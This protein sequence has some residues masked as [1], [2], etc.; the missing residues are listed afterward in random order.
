[1]RPADEILASSEAGGPRKML[2][3]GWQVAQRTPS[4]VN[5]VARLLNG[6]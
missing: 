4:F 3:L 5:R 2:E 1:L 6:N